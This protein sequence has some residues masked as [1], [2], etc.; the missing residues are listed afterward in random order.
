M[1]RDDRGGMD[2][3]LL[4]MDSGQRR[5]WHR[6]RW[7]GVA[8][9]QGS[10]G[11]GVVVACFSWVGGGQKDSEMAAGGLGWRRMSQSAARSFLRIRG[12]FWL[13]LG[14]LAGGGFL[15]PRVGVG[16]RRG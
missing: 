4:R 10:V 15:W 1:R 14:V 12:F 16:A 11:D 5:A 3:D 8:C 13:V 9:D 2:G 6:L 7:R